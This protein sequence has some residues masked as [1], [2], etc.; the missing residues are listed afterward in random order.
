MA[1][2][3][4]ASN[5]PGSSTPATK[6]LVSAGVAHQ[7][8]PYQHD[9]ANQHFGEEAVAALGQDPHQVFKTLVVTLNGSNKELAVAVLPVACQ[10]DLKAIAQA[11]RAKKAALAD[12]AVAE[13][14]TGYLVGGISP[15]GQKKA[16]P[17]LL[18]SSASGFDTIMVSAGRRGLQ[19]ELA[20]DDLLALVG[21]SYAALAR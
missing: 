3:G 10:L 5:T 6:V 19:L 2:H 14:T 8:H 18:D 21:G 1:A 17:T 16:L 20:P 11:C 7:L 4:S 12:H 15:L 9:P 13:R